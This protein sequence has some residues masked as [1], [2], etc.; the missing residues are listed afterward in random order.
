MLA[1]PSMALALRARA[2]PA[3]IITPCR[4]FVRA[5]FFRE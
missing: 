1:P 5:S 4:S 2:V 3:L